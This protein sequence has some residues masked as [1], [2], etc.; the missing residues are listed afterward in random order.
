MTVKTVA[1]I[2]AGQ[3]MAIASGYAQ[4]L[5]AMDLPRAD[6]AQAAAISRGERYAVQ[7]GLAV[8]P[9]RGMITPNSAMLEKYLGWTT[10]HGIEATCRD[11][12]ANDDVAAAVLALDS[13]GGFVVGVQGAAAAVRALNAVKPVYALVHP[14]AASAAYWIASGARSISITPGSMVG[15]IGVLANSSAAIG[16]GSD[17][18][19]DFEIASRN[20]RAKRPDP[21]TESGRAEIQRAIDAIE[22]GFHADVA[23][24][25]GVSVEELTRAAS[26]SDDPADG[27]AVFWGQEAVDRGLADTVEAEADFWARLFDE[28]APK[29]AAPRTARAALAHAACA[30]ARAAI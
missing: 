21:S 29:P 3:M 13:P 6:G 2:C 16:A 26:V 22:A 9:V 1:Q 30:K 4:E 24:G 25:R 27:G 5:M 15:S 20:A 8:V 19:Q 7:R 23:A 11:L 12:A 10:C 28:Y 18:Y 14:L 17:G